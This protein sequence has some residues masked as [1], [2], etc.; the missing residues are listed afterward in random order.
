M[1]LLTVPVFH[2]LIVEAGM[3]PVWFGILAVVAVEAGLI[4][5]P[6]GMNLYVVRAGARGLTTGQLMTGVLPFLAADI[7]RLALLLAVPALALWLP[8]RL[9]G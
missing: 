4:S 5:P 8:G 9:G 6:V 3:D 1:I 2:P 7:L